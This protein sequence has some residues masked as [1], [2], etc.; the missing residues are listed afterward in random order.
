MLVLSFTGFDP[1]QTSAQRVLNLFHS[2]RIRAHGVRS[3]SGA[4]AWPGPRGP[5][6]PRMLSI[7]C[8]LY[9]AVAGLEARKPAA[10]Q[11][12]PARP[13]PEALHASL[14]DWLSGSCHS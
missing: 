9:A 4:N 6:Q 7:G 13:C 2:R 5:R 11:L 14:S 1:E 10:A 3:V 8:P 12:H